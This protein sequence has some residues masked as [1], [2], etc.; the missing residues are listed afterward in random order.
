MT[1]QST[2]NELSVGTFQVDVTPGEGEAIEYGKVETIDDSLSCRGIVLLGSSEPIVLVSIDWI[3]VYN[4][5]HDEWRFQLANAAQTSPDRVAVHTVHQHEAPG[6]DTDAGNIL[7]GHNIDH[8]TIDE[9]FGFASIRRTAKAVQNA[10]QEAEPITHVGFGTADVER[11]ASNRQLL[12]QDG[13]ILD[14]R[15]SSESDPKVRSLPEGLIDP[16]VRIVS[17]WN[18]DTPRVALSYYATHPQSYYGDRHVTCDFV[19]LARNNR[20]AETGVPHVHFNGAAGNIVAGKY[21]D[22]SQKARQE[23]TQRLGEGMKKAWNQTTR[24]PVGPDSISW[25]TVNVK[26]PTA[27]DLTRS[28][29]IHALSSATGHGNT[30]YRDLLWRTRRATRPI[31]SRLNCTTFLE[32]RESYTTHGNNTPRIARDLAWI[33]RRGNGTSIPFGCLT[34]SD[35]QILHLPGE[36]FVEYQLS[37]AELRPEAPVLMAAYGDGAPGYIGT[38]DAYKRGGFGVGFRSKVSPDAENVIQSAV[39]DLL[40][41]PQ[42]TN[43]ATPSEITK[44][45]K[46][47]ISQS[48]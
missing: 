17:L 48:E 44:N 10:I 27:D 26:L 37:A 29:L 9:S 16:T 25:D 32:L 36:P 8:E 41:T 15:Y 40:D 4:G 14:V 28:S 23:L 35:I 43:S 12:D 31:R 45:R 5:G 18:K 2:Q 1:Q 6:F 47:R 24:E 39:C 30:F 7:L 46:P 33:T 19:G 21:N 3:G 20:E 42:E 13:N 22:G 11:V 38:T 34:L